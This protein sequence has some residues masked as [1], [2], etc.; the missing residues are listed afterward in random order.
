LPRGGVYYATPSQRE[1][2]KLAWADRRE[3]LPT[4]LWAA[5]GLPLGVPVAHIGGWLLATLGFCWVA[6]RLIPRSRL[7]FECANCE[8]LSCRSCSGEHDG[9]VLCVGCAQTAKRA[10]SEVVLTT[11]L[12][13]R[14]HEAERAR[15]ARMRLWNAWSFGGGHLQQGRQRGIVMGI[16]LSLF[17]TLII[18]PALPNDPWAM[19]KHDGLPIGRIVGAAGLLVLWIFAFLGR[20]PLRTPPLHIHPASLVSLGDLIEGRPRR[21]ASA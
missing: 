2:W 5:A 18:S 14:R 15:A 9:L 6:T 7:V 10:R 20:V 19:L 1:Y 11:L 13:N 4:D 8:V 17:V 16:F 3:L 12:R 21:R